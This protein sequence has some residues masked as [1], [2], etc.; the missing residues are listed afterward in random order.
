MTANGFNLY[1]GYSKGRLSA[2][3]LSNEVMVLE[4]FK[5]QVSKSN[6][7]P[8]RISTED[9]HSEYSKDQLTK[10]NVN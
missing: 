5:K 8:F 6:Y 1:I 7:T 10:L 9:F 4:E 3:Q 2:Y